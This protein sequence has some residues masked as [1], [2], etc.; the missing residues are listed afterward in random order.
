MLEVPSE[1]TLRGDLS[2]LTTLLSEIQETLLGNEILH[3]G[4][5]GVCLLGELRLVDP[6]TRDQFRNL[7]RF[8]QTYP[9][10]FFRLLVW[11]CGCLEVF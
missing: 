5:H 3:T 8:H 6:E 10:K 7:D 2:P 1:V 9:N 4:Y 11:L